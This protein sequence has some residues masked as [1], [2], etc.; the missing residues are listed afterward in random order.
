MNGILMM[1]ISIIALVSAYMFYGKW[2]EKKWGVDPNRK[3]PAHELQ[4]DVDYVPTDKQVVFGHQ[5]A[6][7]A[8]AGPINGPIQ[9]AMFGWVPI[10]LWI[11]VGGIFFGAVQDFG[12]LYASVRNKGRSIGYLIELYIGKI[13]KR[14][15]LLFCWLFCILVIA[16]FADIVRKSFGV[17]GLDQANALANGR[18]AST[19]M[20]FILAAVGLGFFFKYV[21]L[22][23]IY[24]TIISIAVLAICITVGML[25]PLSLS[26]NLWLYL[27]YFYILVASVAPVWALLQPRDYLNS[28]LLLVMIFGALLGILVSNPTVQLNAF[29]GF[30]VGGQPMFPILFVTIACGAVSG[31][32]SLV[33]SGTASKQIKNEKDMLPV[34]YGAMLMES[35]LAV[36][37]LIAV[38]SVA[39]NG[40][41][42]AGTPQQI[43]SSA[44][45]GFLEVLKIPYSASFTI[46]SLAVSAFA[47]TSLDSVARIGRLSF[48]EFFQDSAT[49][50]NN[51]PAWQKV[52]TNKYVATVAT[53]VVAFFL[54]RVGYANIW[55]LF[56]SANQLLSA[57]ALAALAVFLK[58]TKKQG[59]ML[60]IPMFIMLAVTLTALTQ[61]IIKIIKTMIDGTFVFGQTGLQIIFAVL[62]L[63]LAIIVI[64]QCFQKIFG[65]EKA[66]EAKA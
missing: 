6:S 2:L 27:V 39:V 10:L 21:K 51:M 44:I 45:A 54:S 26:T 5:F 3:T 66:E 20:F 56:G 62:L 8:G 63:G 60:Y 16:A 9:A 22:N 46:I 18:V 61:I 12:S 59:A 7:I 52:L 58:K 19:S 42:P 40:F 29:N 37:S 34:G 23:A 25:A 55:P 53:L 43:F 35:L 15:F 41:A 65:K 30:V 33:S 32:H 28:Y 13:G 38:G 1:I 49:D 64:V 47:L 31:F 57:L 14:L 17:T 50:E 11:L 24:N 4:D 36:V 48:Q